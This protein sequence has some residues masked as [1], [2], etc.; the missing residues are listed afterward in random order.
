MTHRLAG[1]LAHPVPN[2]LWVI[3]AL[4]W[5]TWSPFEFGGSRA[6][7][8]LGIRGITPETVA[9]LLL[10]I[11][12]AV[13]VAERARRRTPGTASTA[14][15]VAVVAAFAALIEVGQL[16]VPARVTSLADW[17]LNT[18]GGAMAVLLWRYWSADAATRAKVL[19]VITGAL[20]APVLLL[21]VNALA[22][23]PSAF[24]PEDWSGEATVALGEEVGGLRAF[25]GQVDEGSVC[26]DGPAGSRCLGP[27]ASGQ[28]ARA[29]NELVLENDHVRVEA[30]VT[31]ESDEQRGPARI[32]SYAEGPTRRN[33]T[34]GVDRRDLLFRMRTSFTGPNGVYPEFVL[35]GAIPPGVRVRI[36]AE[37][38]DGQIALSSEGPGLSRS[39]QLRPSLLASA[40]IWTRARQLSGPSGLLPVAF[41]A[42]AL[43]L[44]LGL[45]V[46]GT[47]R[48][49]RMGHRFLFLLVAASVPLATFAAGLH[50]Q[51]AEP[52]ASLIAYGIGLV[53]AGR[54][55]R[56]HG[57]APTPDP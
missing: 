37:Y 35:R 50:L 6:Q 53:A 43:F 11:P 16:Y 54:A 57:A 23:L 42:G 30:Q 5:L 48:L 28:E 9:N 33:A 15:L 49:S 4:L 7:V 14:R 47:Q 29:F 22:N 27:G 1:V 17:V 45:I 36:R 2:L 21:N 20:L 3:T 44:P 10:L 31:S 52:V 24:V 40:W 12:L 26:T 8:R 19:T 46:G 18:G 32:V 38:R 56:N 51:P 55:R 34:I 39:W 25:L 41:A 13:N